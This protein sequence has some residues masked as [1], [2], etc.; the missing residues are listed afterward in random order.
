MVQV[1]LFQLWIPILL[2]AVCVFAASS[3]IHMVL[4]WH[5]SDYR[6]LSNEDEV[7]AAIRKGTP[8]PGQYVLPHCADM[9][10]MAKPD[11]QQKFKDGPV[12]FLMINPSGVPVMGAALAKWF[13]FTVLVAFT[14]AYLASRTLAPG[15]H[16]LQVF[17][18]VGAVSFL[19]YGF[20]SIPMAIWMGKPWG[21]AI[22]DLADALIYGMLSAGIFGWLWP[23]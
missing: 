21:S 9:K 19:A 3:L 6:A 17:R 5:A 7:R 1:S 4:K 8:A 22:K 13:A 14:A 10:D 20:G 2:S 23:R 11:M 18:V 12:G 15:T 16:Y